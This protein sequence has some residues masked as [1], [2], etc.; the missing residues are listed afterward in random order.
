MLILEYAPGTWNDP[1]PQIKYIF[2]HAK[3]GE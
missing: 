1:N 3:N 2:S